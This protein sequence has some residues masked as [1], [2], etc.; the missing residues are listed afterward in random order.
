MS[1]RLGDGGSAASCGHAVNSGSQYV[2]Q[3]D[4]AREH[5]LAGS[6]IFT[7][8]EVAEGERQQQ[9]GGVSLVAL[10]AEAPEG[11]LRPLR[12]AET[13]AP[14]QWSLQEEVADA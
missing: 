13:M 7:E 4:L 8:P 2:A 9:Q 10:L 12:S 5:L 6:W 3:G 11:G 1:W 14:W